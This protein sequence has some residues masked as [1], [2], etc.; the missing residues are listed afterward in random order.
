MKKSRYYATILMKKKI[1]THEIVFALLILVA[2][3]FL[4]LRFSVQTSNRIEMQNKDYAADAGQLK[5]QQIDEE[6]NNA[7]RQINTYAY[8]AGQSLTEPMITADML[9][10]IEES[11]YFDAIMFT[12]KEGIA[13]DSDGRTADATERKFYNDGIS[14]N[15][16]IEIIYEPYFFDETMTCFY[17]PVRFD[18]QIIGVLRGAFLAEEYLK[19]MLTTTYF[20][21]DAQ[22]FLCSPDG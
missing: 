13:Y 19:N 9:K 10:Q 2:V 6:L 3:I 7:L 12:D 8:F 21:E 11:S 14:G 1:F 20:G 17:A 4:F 22:V 16:G 15:N 5:T 18:G